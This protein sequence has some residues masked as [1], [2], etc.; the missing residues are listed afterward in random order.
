MRNWIESGVAF[1]F[2]E[3]ALWTAGYV[4]ALLGL[5]ALVFACLMTA[6]GA[7]PA[8]ELGL[9]PRNWVRG[10]WLVPAAAVLALLMLWCGFVSGTFHYPA[11]WHHPWM[12]AGLYMTWAVIQEFLLISFL[13]VRLHAELGWYARAATAGIFSVAHLPNAALMVSTFL[14]SLI[15]IA[16][17]RRY[18]NLLAIGIAHAILGIGLAVSMPDSIVHKMLVGKAYLLRAFS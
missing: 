12:H 18:R 5:A 11:R 4:Q 15:L 8:V 3:A 1:G 6:L 10:W 14:L 2:I 7:R 16:A 9:A 17:F 13:Y